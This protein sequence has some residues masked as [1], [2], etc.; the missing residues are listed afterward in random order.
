MRRGPDTGAEER[1]LRPKLGQARADRHPK[2]ALANV[3]AAKERAGFGSGHGDHPAHPTR[4][5]S[6]RGGVAAW[7]AGRS[8][9]AER[10]RR[11]VVKARIVRHGPRMAPLTAHL[12]YLRR[13]GVTRDGEPARMFNA[14]GEH[15]DASAFARQAAGDRHHFRFIVSPED[16]ADLTDL[17][18][19]TRDL[20]HEME[21]DLGTTLDWIAVDHWNTDN[22]HVHLI[23]RGKNDDGHDLV[24]HREYISRG[25]R[26]RAQDLATIELG[27]RAEHEIR[28]KLAGEVVEER[29]TQLDRTLRRIAAARD[30]GVIDMRPECDGIADDRQIRSLLI[31]RLQRLETMGLARPMG[32]AQWRL[33][34]DAEPALRELGTR[35]DIIRIMN[36]SLGQDAGDA[37]IHAV[38]G[39]E[40]PVIGRVVA[41][42]LDDELAGKSYL[43]VEGIDGR[44][45]YVRLGPAV[46]LSDI[47]EGGVVRAT[48]SRSGKWPSL[49]VLSD[50]SLNG[51]VTA[52]GATW[53]DRELVGREK[54]V[55]APTGFGA[56]V[57][58]A[59]DRRVDHLIEEDLVVRRGRQV[60]FASDLLG[61]L[62]R[63][64]LADIAQAITEK[65]GLALRPI[66]DGECVAGIYQRRINLASGRF[67]L[68]ADEVSHEFSLVP[69]RPDVER[70]LGQEISV[71]Q[72]GR[73]ADWTLGRDRGLEIE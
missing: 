31:G 48:A 7:R 5:S 41:K 25:M 4:P 42:G 45:H 15:A 3:L 38:T 51:Q 60:V 26:A 47:P 36:H 12:A 8:L 33:A 53:L 24:I 40:Q 65:T 61:T 68:I 22:P 23:V 69:W 32:P 66:K 1:R 17:H 19:Y 64:E 57:R 63:R 54:S 13:E 67:V 58:E 30:G 52:S 9:L 62:E 6:G 20:V 73:S 44:S 56:E 29:W 37:A 71:T 14:D 59:L 2:L 50:L 34:D 16:A 70:A 35:G 55:L 49:R 39:P 10:N 46:D 28:A 21:R 43:I 11:V 72:R 27:P 18:A